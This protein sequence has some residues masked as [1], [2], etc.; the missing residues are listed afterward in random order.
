MMP[1]QTAKETLTAHAAF[2]LYENA[3]ENDAL[4]Q[5]EWHAE[6]DG[7]QL[8]CALGTLGPDIQRPSDCPATVMPRWLAQMVP[9]FFDKQRFDD[10]KAWGLEF[11]KALDRIGGN[12][13]FSVIHDWQ[14]NTVCQLGIDAAAK[15]GRDTAPHVALQNLHKRALAGEKITADEWRPVLKNA[16]ANAY[17][18]AYADA[19][20]Y[21]YADADADADADAC[22]RDDAC[23]QGCQGCA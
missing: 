13:P 14:A 23:W 22:A 12:V 3:F 20:A 6:R 5:G 1:A 7:R 9:A 21:A 11:Y 17:A 2:R 10:A 19:Y 16:Y 18:Y 8:A 4:I 15:R